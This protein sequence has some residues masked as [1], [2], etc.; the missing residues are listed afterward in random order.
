MMFASLAWPDA[1]VISV[2]IAVFGLVLSVL[3]SQIF[4]TDRGDMK[5]QRPRGA[6]HLVSEKGNRNDSAHHRS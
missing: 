6:S 2:A 3:V 5:Q 4:A 1:V